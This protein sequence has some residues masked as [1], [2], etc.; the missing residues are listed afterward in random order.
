[1][2]KKNKS[3]E[4]ELIDLLYKNRNKFSR[5]T[6]YLGLVNDDYNFLKG[7][8]KTALG[9]IIEEEDYGKHLERVILP[10]ATATAFEFESKEDLLNIKPVVIKFGLPIEI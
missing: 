8:I 3:K 4:L 6:N 10:Y 7:K 5:K 2:E 1:M 9:S